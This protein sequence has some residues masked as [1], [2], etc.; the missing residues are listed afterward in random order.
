MPGAVFG[1]AATSLRGCTGSAS[2]LVESQLIAL[3]TRTR[4]LDGCVGCWA[5]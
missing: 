4:I 2:E 5:A 3:M 1:Q